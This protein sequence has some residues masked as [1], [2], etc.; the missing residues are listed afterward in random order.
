MFALITLFLLSFVAAVNVT[1]T[2]VAIWNTSRIG[3][4]SNGSEDETPVA[5]TNTNQERIRAIIMAGRSFCGKS[6]FGECQT[7]SDC[8]VGGCAGQVCQSKNEEQ[9]VTTCEYQD[10][11]NPA[12]YNLSCVCIKNKCMWSRLTED[13]IKKIIKKENKINITARVWE[14]PLECT[15]TGSTIKCTLAN[16]REMTVYAGKSGNVIVQVKGENMMTNVTLY[17][18]D[19]KIYGVFRNNETREIK[20]LPDQVRERIR[21]RLQRQL[22]NENITLDEDGIYRYRAHKRARLFAFIPVTLMVR[23][24]IDPNTGEII[25]ISK[26]PWW[27]FL[28]KDESQQ[29]VGASCGTV[30]PG[31]NDAC[32]VNK[33]YNFWNNNTNQCEFL[34]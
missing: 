4:V 26:N 3:A 2:T 9:A 8:I 27:F 16:G 10:C 22:E 25:K 6:T 1:I 34:P 21:E 15:C 33:G 12:I 13:K 24:E 5:A 23:A 19:K 32:C 20:M 17:K 28:A 14:C 31:E 29:I 11:Y 7:D 18:L 30:T